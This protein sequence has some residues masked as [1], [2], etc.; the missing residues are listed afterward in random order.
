MSLELAGILLTFR[1]RTNWLG[2]LL[3][4]AAS[5]GRSRVIWSSAFQ[6]PERVWGMLVG[7]GFRG[8]IALPPPERFR[9]KR[10]QSRTG[11]ALHPRCCIARTVPAPP[12]A[13]TRS[14]E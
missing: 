12:P 10:L 1:P 6:T 4:T 7:Y 8:V 11:Q 14:S 9:A 3:I 2:R 13:Q 5:C